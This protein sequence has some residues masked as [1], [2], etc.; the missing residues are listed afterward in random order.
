M[1]FSAISGKCAAG[2]V[3][4]L[5]MVVSCSKIKPSYN[6]ENLKAYWSVKIYDGEEVDPDRWMVYYFQNNGTL[7]ITGI[8]NTGDGGFSWGSSKLSYEAY[9]C[10]LSYSGEINGFFGIPVSAYLEREYS[11]FESEDSLVTLELIA[12]RLNGETIYSDHNRVTM[13]KLSPKYSNTDSLAGTWQTSTVNGEKFEGW[14]M[15]FDSKGA[16]VMQIQSVSGRWT[17]VGEDG[18]YSVYDDFA[19]VTVTDNEY[20]GIPGHQDVVMFTDIRATPSS[21]RMSLVIDGDEYVF[22]Y[23]APV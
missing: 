9:C 16:F 22:T 23:V 17:P 4:L 11:F 13:T 2:A 21:S 18:K 5:L 1:S 19:A 10:D 8:R 7:E 14:R 20:I 15:K 12:E 3:V 6:R